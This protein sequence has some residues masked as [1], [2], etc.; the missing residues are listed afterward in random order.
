ML[1]V[2]RKSDI[3]GKKSQ[4]LRS[5]DHKI[6]HFIYQALSRAFTTQDSILESWKLVNSVCK[7]ERQDI[8]FHFSGKCVKKWK[9]ALMVI[10]FEC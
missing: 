1:Q 2:A 3:P 6:S 4:F 5:A 10:D 9:T 7:S 8:F